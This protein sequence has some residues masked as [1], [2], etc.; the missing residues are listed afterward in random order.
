M[1]FL[2]DGVPRQRAR[3]LMWLELAKDAAPAPSDAWIRDLY[4][5]DL[6]SASDGD[7]QAAASLHDVRAKQALPSAP[8]RDVVKFILK[9]L[10]IGPL[11]GSAPP[12]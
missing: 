8:V 6:A 9:P 5:R 2:G 4:Q 7:R 11:A 3:G 1:L 12:Q 10:Q